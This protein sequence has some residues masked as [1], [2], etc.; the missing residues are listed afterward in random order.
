MLIIDELLTYVGAQLDISTEKIA[1]YQQRQ[2]TITEQR[3]AILNHLD[4]R[5]LGE[6]E[7]KMLEEFLFTEVTRLEQTGPL[8]IQAKQFLKEAGILFPADDTLRRIIARHQ[9]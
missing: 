6:S 9:R 1:L 4:L 8:I 5:R 7:M 3:Q 2:A